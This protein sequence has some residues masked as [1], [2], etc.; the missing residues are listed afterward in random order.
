MPDLSSPPVFIPAQ[1][2]QT[3]DAFDLPAAL[4]AYEG[5]GARL[6]ESWLDIELYARFSA[7]IADIRAHAVPLPALTVLALQLAIAHSELVST[8][9]QNASVG[10]DAGRIREVV[11]RHAV[12]LDALRTAATTLPK[13]ARVTRATIQVDQA[14]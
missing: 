2:V 5:M 3:R 14:R 1:A 12:A 13:T 4:A 11:E 7:Q 8:M 10:V 6:V 9:W